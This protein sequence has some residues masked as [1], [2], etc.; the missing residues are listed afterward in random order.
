MNSNMKNT[1]SVLLLSILGEGVFLYF[2]LHLIYLKTVEIS[3][4]SCAV[5]SSKACYSVTTVH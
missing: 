4:F 2:P 5:E 1:Y 3:Y